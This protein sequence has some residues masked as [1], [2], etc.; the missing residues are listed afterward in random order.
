[1]IL[2]VVPPTSNPSLKVGPGFTD[3]LAVSTPPTSDEIFDAKS[4]TWRER[5]MKGNIDPIAPYYA[6]TGYFLCAAEST[7]NALAV[8]NLIAFLASVRDNAYLVQGARLGLIPAREEM[9][10]DSGR[11]S[12]GYGLPGKLTADFFALI[13]DNLRPLRWAT[14]LRVANAKSFLKPLGEQ[15][16]RAVA[17]TTSAAT[18][19]Q[20]AHQ[21]WQKELAARGDVFVDEYRTSHGFSPRIK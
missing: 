8:E 5:R 18:A 20:K 21:A 12:S 1:M 4:K 17:G 6:T 14:D 16:Q 19:L 13:R 9:L 2:V 7:K 11:F 3:R 15:L 10:N